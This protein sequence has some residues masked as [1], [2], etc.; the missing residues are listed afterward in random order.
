MT[1][2]QLFTPT[3]KRSVKELFDEKRQILRYG[4]DQF[5]FLYTFRRLARS[6]VIGRSNVHRVTT[7]ENLFA[8]REKQLNAGPQVRLGMTGLGRVTNVNILNHTQDENAFNQLEE[9]VIAAHDDARFKLQAL[10]IQQ[11]NHMKNY[12]DKDDNQNHQAVKELLA[13]W[14]STQIDP[15]ATD[16]SSTRLVL[17]DRNDPDVN[18]LEPTLYQVKEVEEF[19]QA[20]KEAGGEK[21]LLRKWS[22]LDYVKPVLERG[23]VEILE[24]FTQEFAMAKINARLTQLGPSERSAT[25]KEGQAPVDEEQEGE[26]EDTEEEIVESKR[27]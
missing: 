3:I 18:P 25:F 19:E 22:S 1:T 7:F 9:R 20:V 17:D 6:N 16:T 2:K 13:A 11:W 15:E 24:K 26:E 23:Q 10:K 14:S 21:K 12:G 27:H 4:K 8:R 5:V